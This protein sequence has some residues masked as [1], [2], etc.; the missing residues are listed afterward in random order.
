MTQEIVSSG[1]TVR[2]SQAVSQP[3]QAVLEMFN[4]RRV[5][6]PWAS[7]LRQSEGDEQ[8][9]RGEDNDVYSV[10]EIEP[11]YDIEK[12]IAWRSKNPHHGTCVERGAMALVGLGHVN[13]EIHD[14]LDPYCDVDGNWQ[15][16]LNSCASDFMSVRMFY[17]EVVRKPE[18]RELVYLAYI[19]AHLPKVVALSNNEYYFRISSRGQD[20]YLP[21]FGESERPAI[22]GA[23]VVFGLESDRKAGVVR[24]LLQV[25][26]SNPYSRYYGWPD[27]VSALPHMEWASL[28]VQHSIDRHVNRSQMGKVCE[29]HEPQG[30][31]SSSEV[32]AEAKKLLNDV[33]KGTLEP[34]K[35]F[36]NA[37]IHLVGGARLEVHELAKEDGA[38]SVQMTVEA[39]V[40]AA[41]I[42]TAHSIPPALANV[43]IPGKLG[44]ANEMS[45]AMMAAQALLFGPLQQLISNALGEAF[46]NVV[47]RRLGAEEQPAV[48]IAGLTK[49][50]FCPKPKPKKGPDGQPQP[51]GQMDYLT[52]FVRITDVIGVAVADTVGRMKQPLS[53]AKAEG[54][55]LSAGQK[56]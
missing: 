9:V 31:S 22:K 24:E 44:A 25:K 18:T 47:K 17:I 15:D 38:T 37:V 2:T 51:D 1:T 36:L 26:K 10:G 53:D 40:I 50:H 35:A 49:E 52:G 27:W 55:D 48:T 46:G 23:G 30:Q 4:P 11:P 7:R 5:D 56:D 54:R 45:N 29:I 16:L 13:R 28:A 6:L 19:P 42:V 3:C 34:G 32:H 33:L 12:A 8:T 39:D 21:R 14:A 41:H 43:Q 20:I